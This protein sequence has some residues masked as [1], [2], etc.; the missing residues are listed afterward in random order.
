MKIGVFYSYGP[1][2]LDAIK[3]IYNYYPDEEIIVFLPENYP[4]EKHLVNIEK[5]N[6]QFLPWDGSHLTMNNVLFTLPKIIRMLRKNKLDI[7]VI[8][9]ESPRLIFLSKMTK[10]KKV[11]VFNVFSEYKA[12]EKRLL[13][14]LF[15][16]IKRIMKGYCS[17]LHIYFYTKLFP[18]KKDNN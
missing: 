3:Y 4:V 9:F 11:Y 10:A 8:L 13:S 12:L 2:L 18:I 7:L 15:E 5:V 17:Y 6:I 16:S 14:T 1:H